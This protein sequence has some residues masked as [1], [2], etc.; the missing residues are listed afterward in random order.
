MHLCGGDNDAIKSVPMSKLQ[1]DRDPC[2]S[3]TDRNHSEIVCD[4]SEQ[5]R[6]RAI[7]QPTFRVKDRGFKQDDIGN[8]QTGLGSLGNSLP[9]PTAKPWI[10]QKCPDG[11]MRI[12]TSNHSEGFQSVS[13]VVGWSISSAVV[14][15]PFMHP[16]MDAPVLSTAGYPPE[17]R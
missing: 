10:I 9:S 11:G 15:I 8:N 14:N 16:R 4:F 7:R 17:W 6:Q 13:E 2:N 1:F 3:R 12:H 5:F